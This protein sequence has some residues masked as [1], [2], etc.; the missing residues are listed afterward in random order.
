MSEFRRRARSDG[1]SSQV[2]G[3]VRIAM[4]SAINI[5]RNSLQRSDYQAL[6]TAR[7]YW[8]KFMDDSVWFRV[9]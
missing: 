2:S 8:G 1:W 7:D 5:A 9:S 4:P 6:N 3:T